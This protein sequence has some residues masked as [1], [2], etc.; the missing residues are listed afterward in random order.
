LANRSPT[1]CCSGR[2]IRAALI[3]EGLSAPLNTGV[4]LLP[5]VLSMEEQAEWRTWNLSG[6]KVTQLRVDS[7]FHLHMWSLERDLLITFG[8]PFTLRS[9]E[10]EVQTF[11]PERSMSLCPLLSLMHRSVETFAASSIGECML[12]FEDGSELRGVPHESY[13]AW[14]SHGTGELEGASL[15]CGV[16]A[17]SP[18]D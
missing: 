4:G 7:Q 13:E 12:R 9:P 11:D 3:V 5:F 17:S 2:T 1:R 15:L 10:A 14:E 6:L 8:T 18:W 16:G